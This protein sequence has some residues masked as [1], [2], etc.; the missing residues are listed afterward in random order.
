MG[1][2]PRW[3]SLQEGTWA[4]VISKETPPRKATWS[5]Q[6][7][8]VVEDC[9]SLADEPGPAW[10]PGGGK[11]AQEPPRAKSAAPE[12]SGHRGRVLPLT[13]AH[14]RQGGD[15]VTSSPPGGTRVR[16]EQGGWDVAPGSGAKDVTVGT[17]P[18]GSRC[19]RAGRARLRGART[20]PTPLLGKLAAPQLENVP[21]QQPPGRTP[22]GTS[23]TREGPGPPRADPRPAPRL[24]PAFRLEH[25]D[26]SVLLRPQITHNRGTAVS[27]QG[28]PRSSPDLSSGPSAKSRGRHSDPSPEVTSSTSRSVSSGFFR[29]MPPKAA[30]SFSSRKCSGLHSLVFEAQSRCP[31]TTRQDAVSAAAATLDPDGKGSAGH[32]GKI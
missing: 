13:L 19:P 9:P 5:G 16:A 11:E 4:P 17:G 15:D 30:L 18:Q 27:G 23:C 22:A 10:N 31:Q 3:A 8:A 2:G 1:Q 20:L 6:R 32:V 21:A 29:K 24:R 26:P 25:L 14:L 28:S 7:T 12:A